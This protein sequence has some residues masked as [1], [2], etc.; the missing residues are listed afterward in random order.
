MEWRAKSSDQLKICNFTVSKAKLKENLKIK[1][2]W[3][4]WD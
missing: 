2:L 1:E 4:L 3:K